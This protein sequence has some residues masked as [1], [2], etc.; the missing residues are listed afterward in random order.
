MKHADDALDTRM[1]E[2]DIT[3]VGVTPHLCTVVPEKNV[4]TVYVYNIN[5]QQPST[6]RLEVR[7][8]AQSQRS[9]QG[10]RIY[11]LQCTALYRTTTVAATRRSIST[12]PS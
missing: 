2:T 4:A 9:K 8:S 1:N 6:L 5:E 11:G 12:T 7:G 3:E 10:A